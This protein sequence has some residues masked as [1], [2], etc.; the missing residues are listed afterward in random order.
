MYFK[1]VQANHAWRWEV[2]TTVMLAM[3]IFLYVA[4][5]PSL[6]CEVALCF[7]FLS[8][9]V[10]LVSA[11]PRHEVYDYLPGT[12]HRMYYK[13]SM[14]G[15]APMRIDKRRAQQRSFRGHFCAKDP[16][17][18]LRSPLNPGASFLTTEVGR[19]YQIGKWASLLFL[20]F[21]FFYG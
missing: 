15:S 11:Q 9:F 7:V 10:P 17:K 19:D 3:L 16:T 13:R 21:F 6:G 20:A 14:Y 8:F 12:I 4:P 2:M 5:P 1:F 18:P